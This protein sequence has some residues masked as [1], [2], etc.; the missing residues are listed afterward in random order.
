MIT[1]L[2]DDGDALVGDAAANML[3]FA[4]TKY[5][6]IGLNDLDE[7]YRSWQKVIACNAQRIF[8]AHGNPFSVEKLRENIGKNKKQNIVMMHL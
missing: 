2:F 3:Q 6:V 5:C 1:I 4:G 7:Y 8:P